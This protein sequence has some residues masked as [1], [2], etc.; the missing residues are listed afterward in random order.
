MRYL[1]AYDILDQGLPGGSQEAR[2]RQVA[3]ICQGCGIRVQ[4]SV[5]E[6]DLNEPQLA[7]LLV[8]LQDVI[9]KEDSVRIYRIGSDT[10]IM[11]GA[12][13]YNERVNSFII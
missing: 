1:V 11:L 7:I 2:L 3:R 12:T 4:Y 6:C 10:T 13:A 9:A 8:N 5:F